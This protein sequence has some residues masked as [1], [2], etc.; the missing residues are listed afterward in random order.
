MTG[1]SNMLT[2][3]LI[4]EEINKLNDELL[5]KKPA[6][7]SNRRKVILLH[8]NGRPH[9]AK[10]VKETLLQLKWEILCVQH[11]LIFLAYSRGKIIVHP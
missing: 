3:S 7:A 4:R 11:S 8:D 5:R 6:I 1:A 10:T 2:N 9:I